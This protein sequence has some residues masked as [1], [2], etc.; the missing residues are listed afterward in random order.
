MAKSSKF[1]RLDEDILVEFIYHDQNVA[2]VDEAKIENDDNGS[3]LKY[4]NVVAG[5]DN[6]DRF[7]IHELGGDVVN[8]TVRIGNGF[9]Y[10]NDFASRELILKNGLTYKFDLSDASIDNISGFQI[11]GGNTQ[12]NGNIL[13]YTPNTNGDYSYT[14]TNLAGISSTGGNIKVGNRANSLYA[15]PDQVTGNTIHTAPGESG[16]YYAVP[17]DEDNV[18]ALLDNSLD[19]LDSS[20]WQGTTSTGLTVVPV[21]D[22][23]HVYYDTIRLHLRTGYSFSGR[24]LD[25]F[26]FQVSARRNNNSKGYLTSI[27]YKNS[28]SFEIQNPKPFILADSSFSKYIEI[29]VPALVHANDPAKNEDFANTFFGTSGAELVNGANY[30]LNL[31][32]IH[33]TKTV[34]GYEYIEI[35]NQSE[36]TLSQEDELTDLSVQLEENEDYFNIYG[37]KDGSI[38]GFENYINGRIQESSDDIT[39]FYDLDVSEQLGLSYVSTYQMTLVQT[40]DFDQPLV[41]RPVIRNAAFCSSFLIRVAMRIYNET[42]NTQILK[43]AS[44]IYDKPKKYGRRMQQIALKSNDSSNIVYNMLPNSSV[45]TQLNNFVNSIR[46]DVG[47]TKYVPVAIDTYGI[48]ASS[49]NI[50]RQGA[51][52]EATD[53]LK[54]ENENDASVTLSKVADNFIKFSIAKPKGDSLESISLVNA[55]DVILTIKSGNI[56]QQI[57]HNPNFPDIDMGAGEVLFKVTKAVASRFDQPDT[58]SEADKF[59]ITLK[60][61]T[62]ESLLFHGKINII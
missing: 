44:L 58:N 50:A 31:S 2:N 21:N 27:V 24:G 9:I 38:A 61:G 52:V 48:V 45:N 10:I 62:T 41:F 26:L 51:D 25:G 19:Y 14:Y 60:N 32:M 4:L 55:E 53:E 8:F 20:E 23:Q 18:F 12:L 49:S 13:T 36:L 59:Y 39:V 40:A 42:D 5:D 46:P 3:Q 28:S 33:Q 15:T 47:E 11:Q 56:E 7:L 30:Q 43:M 1:A 34:N 29:K 16:R 54:Y 57:S 35:S 17:T 6:A 22:V 37:L